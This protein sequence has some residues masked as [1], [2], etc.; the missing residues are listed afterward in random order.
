MRLG[1]GYGWG[2]YNKIMLWSVDLDSEGR[3]WKY[4]QPK[5]KNN[6]SKRIRKSK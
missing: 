1:K 2:F 3:I 4:V 6:K 5:K